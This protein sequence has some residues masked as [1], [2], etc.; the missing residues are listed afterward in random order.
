MMYVIVLGSGAG[1]KG[2]L[3]DTTFCF[4]VWLLERAPGRDGS[5]D[6]HIPLLRCKHHHV[7]KEVN[8][9]EVR[10]VHGYSRVL[11]GELDEDCQWSVATSPIRY[12]FVHDDVCRDAHIW[13]NNTNLMILKNLNHT[14]PLMYQEPG[15][16]EC[17]WNDFVCKTNLYLEANTQQVINVSFELPWI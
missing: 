11:E 15:Q 3:Q 2:P 13:R 14:R 16:E 6:I 1:V 7:H 17:D 9:T 4:K 10:W 5:K 8:T 12:F